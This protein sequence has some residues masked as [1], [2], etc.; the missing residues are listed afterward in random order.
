MSLLPFIMSNI[1]KSTQFNFSVGIEFDM[2]NMIKT[3]QGVDSISIIN[4]VYSYIKILK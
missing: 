2:A 4:T 3:R 1:Q